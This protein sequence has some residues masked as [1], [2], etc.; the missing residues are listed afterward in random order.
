VSLTMSLFTLS[1]LVPATVPDTS[2][3]G[4]AATTTTA[5]TVLEEG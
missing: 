3:G 5:T 1:D 2:D 4:E